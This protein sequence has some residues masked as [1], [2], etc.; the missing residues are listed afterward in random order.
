MD[1]Q[2]IKKKTLDVYM[3][4]ME[5]SSI[6][7]LLYAPAMRNLEAAKHDLDELLI[8]E[9]ETENE[10]RQEVFNRD[11]QNR[12]KQANYQLRSQ[13]Q[14]LK[15]QWN[16]QDS[17]IIKLLDFHVSRKFR[18]TNSLADKLALKDEAVLRSFFDHNIRPALNDANVITVS[19]ELA[20][21][22]TRDMVNERVKYAE[23]ILANRVMKAQVKA[24]K[25]DK[26]DIKGII[27]HYLQVEKL[28][29]RNIR[30]LSASDVEQ[31][32]QKVTAEYP[33]I[34][35][36]QFDHVLHNLKEKKVRSQRHTRSKKSV[37]RVVSKKEKEEVVEVK[38]DK[39]SRKESRK[40][41]DKESAPKPPKPRKQNTKEFRVLMK[42]KKD[43]K[44]NVPKLKKSEE[45]RQELIQAVLAA[46]TSLSTEVIKQELNS[47]LFDKK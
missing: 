25:K 12:L 35:R 31:I 23:E 11:R 4:L 29:K 27:K 9:E 37:K 1:A 38:S 5:K 13:A 41:K 22:I 18:K 7:S 10:Y 2:R 47:L 28:G 34:T 24:Q 32:W 46:D 8:E 3:A 6:G 44:V 40:D 33:Q 30:A 42:V 15:N 19:P 45:K 16:I 36:E 14:N 17:H 39:K 21:N 26:Q 43:L 20:F